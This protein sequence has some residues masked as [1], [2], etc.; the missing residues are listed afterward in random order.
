MIS[1]NEIK[2]T[3]KSFLKK[4]N[5]KNMTTRKNYTGKH[6]ISILINGEEKIKKEFYLNDASN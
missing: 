1:Q 2:T 5:F 4:Q 6:Y 3:S